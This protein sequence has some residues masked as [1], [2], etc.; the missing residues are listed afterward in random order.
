MPAGKWTAPPAPGAT[1]IKRG[2]DVAS[3]TDDPSFLSQIIAWV[4]AGIAGLATWLW[5]STMGRI[6]KL[7]EGKVNQ[8]TFDT[9]VARADKDRDER[10]DTELSLFAEIKDQRLHFDAKLD[11]ITDMLRDRR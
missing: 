3:P 7:E 9:Y 1:P 5:T 4:A 6:A 2:D 10:R 8:K 11:K